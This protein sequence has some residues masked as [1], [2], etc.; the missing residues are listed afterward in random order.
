MSFFCGVFAQKGKFRHHLLI[1]LSFQ[2]YFDFVL[3]WFN[4]VLDTIDLKQSL[5]GVCVSFKDI[6]TVIGYLK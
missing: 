4:V 5:T 1:L 6:H 3:L 2:S